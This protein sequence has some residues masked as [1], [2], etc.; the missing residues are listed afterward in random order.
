MWARLAGALGRPEL[1]ERAEFKTQS[2]RAKNR[3]ALNAALNEA[4]GAKPSAEWIAILNEA[5]VPSGPIYR[6]DQVFADPQV[7]HLQAAAA[8]RH[9]R[10]GE[11][12][13]VNQ[14]VKLSR[15]P[16]ALVT[17]T[18]ERGAH[19]DEILRSLGFADADIAALRTKRVI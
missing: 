6:V 14:P 3:A 19:T 17:A 7:A 5:G 12:R 1:L 2:D 4:F 8:V 13:L 10:L 15:T 18:P 11:L 9:P 16:A